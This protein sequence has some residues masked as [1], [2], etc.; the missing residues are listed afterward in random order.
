MFLFI[1]RPSPGR[2]LV[3]GH[4]GRQLVSGHLAPLTCWPGRPAA[5]SPRGTG[6]KVGSGAW[7]PSLKFEQ[8]LLLSTSSVL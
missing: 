1:P 5:P 7:D 3:S 6:W 2:Q 4:L 8:L